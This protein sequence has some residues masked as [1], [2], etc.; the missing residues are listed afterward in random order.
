MIIIGSTQLTFTKKD[1]TFHC[2]DCDQNS[3]YRQ[4]YKREFLTVYFIPLIPLQKLEEFVEC[5]TCKHTFEPH[6]ATMTAEEIRASRRRGHTEMIRRALVVIVGA[7]NQVTENELQAVQDFALQNDLADVTIE[8]ILHEAASVR[9]S[10]M[11]ALQYISHVATQL[12][13]ED[14]D[15]LVY[16]AFLA[17]T[18]DG[19]LSDT[20]QGILAKLPEAIGVPQ[21]RFREIVANA[22]NEQ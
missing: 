7:D 11:D 10:G 3:A 1:G 8:Q 14:K 21:D 9:Q 22:A 6:I 18:A 12:P 19:E 4:R 13:E 5:S 15:R 16:H 2:P 20:R 17:A